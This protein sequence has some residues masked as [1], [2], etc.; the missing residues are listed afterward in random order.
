MKQLLIF[1][2][3]GHGKVVADA[4][5]QAG[6]SEI[7]FFDDRW[8]ELSALSCWP[9]AGGKQALAGAWLAGGS[10][11][12]AVGDNRR[13]LLLLES[14]AAQGAPLATVFHPSAAVSRYATIGAGSVVFA[15][16]AVNADATLGTGVIVN[17]GASVDHDCILGDGV[18]I[19]PGARLAGQVR[20]GNETWIGIGAVIRDGITIGRGCMVAAGAVIINDVADG[21]RVAGNPGRV[22]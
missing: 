15:T 20:V 2:A 1:G 17:T 18:H 13:R 9:V 22:F 6:W 3:G 19:S 7:I 10:V 11:A 14:F 12:V 16:A 4:A 5:Q 21:C 8:P